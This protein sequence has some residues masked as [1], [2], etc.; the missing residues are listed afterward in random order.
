MRCKDKIFFGD[1]Q[2]KVEI[3]RKNV[4]DIKIMSK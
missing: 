1:L 2:I 3:W 4:E